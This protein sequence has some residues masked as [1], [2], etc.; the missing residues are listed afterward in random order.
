VAQV[1]ILDVHELAAGKLAAL[2]GRDASR[3]LFDTHLLLKRGG[4]DRERL[5]AGFVAYG[6]INRRDWRTVGLDDVNADPREVD[7]QLVPMLR[8]D[9]VPDHKRL[10]EWT[11]NLVAECRD[12]LSLLLPLEPQEREFLDRLNDRGEIAPELL[13]DDAALQVILRSHP[14]LLWKAL[15]VRKHQGLDDESTA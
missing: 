8:G 15:N 13:T 9:V 7:Q 6:G 12:M 14:G 1:P 2:F 4:L 3:D 5:R 10:D 11:R